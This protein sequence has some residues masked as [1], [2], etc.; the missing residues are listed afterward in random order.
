MYVCPVFFSFPIYC[1]F[2]LI[3]ILLA[4]DS[5]KRDGTRPDLTGNDELCPSSLQQLINDCWAQDPQQRPMAHKV[6]K[7]LRIIADEVSVFERE[8]TEGPSSNVPL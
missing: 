6:L 4:D 2:I 1:G 8:S 7:R 5:R 3:L